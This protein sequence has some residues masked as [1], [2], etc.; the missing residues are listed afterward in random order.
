MD[1]RSQIDAMEDELVRLQ[2]FLSLYRERS[3]LDEVPA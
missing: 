2:R 1:L 3:D